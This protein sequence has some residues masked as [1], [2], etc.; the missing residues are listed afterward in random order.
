MKKTK[1]EWNSSLEYYHVTYFE[2]NK[3]S[4]QNGSIHSLLFVTVAIVVAK[5]PN[6][7]DSIAW[8]TD[9]WKLSRIHFPVVN[10]TD[11]QEK[12]IGKHNQSYCRSSV[13]EA[14][15]KRKSCG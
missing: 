14:V 2:E 6:D 10:V 9:V 15:L 12:K 4:K 8:Q 7:I 3:T 11:R 5:V 13:E 1:F